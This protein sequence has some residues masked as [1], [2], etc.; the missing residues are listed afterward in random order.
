[1][2]TAQRAITI[3]EILFNPNFLIADAYTITFVF[4]YFSRNSVGL[5]PL[6][7]RNKRL[8]LESVLKPVLQ[9]IVLT[10]SAVSISIR[11]A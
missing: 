11:A 1:M 3:P 5:Q 2:T 7:L 6:R 10:L 4:W 8:K 9:Q